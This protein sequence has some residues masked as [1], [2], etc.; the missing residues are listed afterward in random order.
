MQH[1]TLDAMHHKC[2]DQHEHSMGFDLI[3]MY[4]MTQAN[5]V[6][7]ALHFDYLCYRIAYLWNM[8]VSEF[9]SEVLGIMHDVNR[10]YYSTW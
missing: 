5:S 9:F 4:I 10:I 7:T 6:N 2:E 8:D 3:K 1:V